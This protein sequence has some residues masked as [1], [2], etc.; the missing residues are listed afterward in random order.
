MLSGLLG[1][2]LGWSAFPAILAALFLQ[3]VLFQYGG[4]MVLGVNTSIM[5]IPAIAVGLAVRPALASCGKKR[6]VAFFAAGCL[7]ILGSSLLMAGCLVLSE[8]GFQN[9][10]LMLIIWNLPI[11]ILEGF[12]TLF[13]I[14]FLSRVQPDILSF[15]TSDKK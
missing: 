13:T 7:P 10:S 3:A 14:E 1:L 8:K 2:I 4:L 11:A 6:M 12:I 15:S 5:S 9:A